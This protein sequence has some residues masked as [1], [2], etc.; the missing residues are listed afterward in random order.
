M[1]EAPAQPS[2]ERTAQVQ[3]NK[4][5]VEMLKGTPLNGVEGLKEMGDVDPGSPEYPAMS[6]QL[7]AYKEAIIKWQKAG[8]PT[9]TNE[10]VQKIHDTHC[11]GCSW[12]DPDK[13]RCKGCGCRV[14]TG[15]VAVLN[16]I[17]MKTEHCPKGEW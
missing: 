10:E 7:W 16:K 8:R 5:I 12:Y 2:V 15:S 17:K 4:E 3:D 11:V 14:T 1:R 9:R 6:L 13:K